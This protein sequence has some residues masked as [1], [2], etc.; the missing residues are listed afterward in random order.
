MPTITTSLLPTLARPEHSAG[1]SAV[2]IDLLRASTTITRAL[3]HGASRV[4]PVLEPDEALEERRRL[5]AAG[6]AHEQIVLGGERGGVLIPGFD[7]DNSPAAYTRERVRGRTIVFTT[8]NGTRALMLARGHGAGLV[9]I[10][11]LNNLAAIVD[12]LPTDRDVHLLCAGTRGEVSMEDVLCAGA[13]AQRLLE[14]GFALPG[15]DQGRIA[16][17]LWRTAA[18]E[19]GGVLRAMRE[20]RG[21]RNLI[22]LG[23]DADLADCARID[24]S[25]LAPRLERGVLTA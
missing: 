6:T 14:R 5:Q 3:E 13:I 9:L 7:L 16:I 17:E 1:C 11:C 12:R 23:F 15:D 4:I 24:C 10:G 2:I 22:R 19:P 25:G 20:S 8:T 18:A 21:G